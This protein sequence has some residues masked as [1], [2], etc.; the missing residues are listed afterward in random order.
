[1][2]PIYT[3]YTAGKGWR[4]FVFAS[5]HNGK[6]TSRQIL[7]RLTGISCRT[8]ARYDKI[9]KVKRK[10][11]I[12]ITNRPASDLSGAVEFGR[13]ATN[14]VFYDTKNKTSKLAHKRPDSRQPYGHPV[15]IC[16]KWEI[17]KRLSSANSG[18]HSSLS[19]KQWANN[20]HVIFHDT[21]KAAEAAARKYGRLDLRIDSFFRSRHTANTNFYS[22]A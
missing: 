18:N 9:A 5:T 7:N 16:S 8:Q 22:L 12:Y 2:L 19:D 14:F 4:A 3:V 17:N 10:A 13:E 15:K 1:V 20:P 6:P 21:R 11:N